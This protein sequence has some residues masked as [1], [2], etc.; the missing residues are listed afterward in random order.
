M[1]AVV[2][3]LYVG[4]FPPRIDSVYAG[5]ETGKVGLGNGNFNY[6][7][8]FERSER[9]YT[10][11]ILIDGSGY[12]SVLGLIDGDYV[13]KEGLPSLLHEDLPR[14]FDL[15]VPEKPNVTPGQDH[16]QDPAVLGY[17]SLDTRSAGCVASV[18]L[19]L[20][21][22]QYFNV[23]LLGFSEGGMVAPFVY[24]KMS[25]A[26]SI[27]HVALASS[28]GYSQYERLRVLWSDNPGKL[29]ELERYKA[30]IEANPLSTEDYWM[31]HTFLRWSGFLNYAPIMDLMTIQLPILLIHGSHDKSVPVES[32]R[33]AFDSLREAGRDDVE[34]IETD[35]GHDTMTNGLD[36]ISDWIEETSVL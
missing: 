14:E 32:S 10:L 18:E 36:D 8:L 30:E 21:Q 15:L 7:Y 13:T 25:S 1:S 31:G 20:S 29:E 23:V 22:R 19:V 5:M 12:T 4:C 2:V 17:Y 11:V 27:S 26:S 3:L 24:T 35:E 9:N 33:S 28:G 16:S 6:Y 34:Y